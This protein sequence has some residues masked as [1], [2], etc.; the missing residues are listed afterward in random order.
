MVCYFSG[1][2][3]KRWGEGWMVSEIYENLLHRKLTVTCETG[4]VVEV[5]VAQI[6][7][8]P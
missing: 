2:G 8:L 1:L 7:L 6:P 5:V 3:G 4:S